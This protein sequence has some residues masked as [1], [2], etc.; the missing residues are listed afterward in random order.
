MQ[1]GMWFR[2]LRGSA[3][4][5]ARSD[6]DALRSARLA[7][8]PRFVVLACAI[9]LMVL[10][11]EARLGATEAPL[12][13]KWDQLVPAAQ[14]KALK[15]F[16]QPKTG[17]Y[18]IAG[19]PGT[20]DAPPPKP[21][22]RWLSDKAPASMPAEVVA[23]LDGKRVRIGGYVVALDFDATSIKEFLLVPFVGACIHV[24][25]PPSN[26]IVYVKA[27]KPFDIKG[28]FDPVWVTGTMK[29]ETASTGLADAGYTIDAESIEARAK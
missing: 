12:E 29:A 16:F 20:G 11:G 1:L 10:A 19:G 25:P 17:A 21:E 24:P 8:V 4:S 18:D 23:A 22:G 6:R 27:A 15:P 7:V 28:Q 14:P 26:Q 5:S 13:L 9:G 2:A 3:M